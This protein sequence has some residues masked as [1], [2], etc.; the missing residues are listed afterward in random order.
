M[1]GAAQADQRVVPK[2]RSGSPRRVGVALGSWVGHLLAGGAAGDRQLPRDPVDADHPQLAQQ[3]CG[4]RGTGLAVAQPV[5]LGALLW[6]KLPG[7]SDRICG[8]ETSYLFP[9]PRRS[10]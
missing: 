6:I 7:E 8:G 1:G 9:R 5:A 10:G 2:A 4:D 3:G